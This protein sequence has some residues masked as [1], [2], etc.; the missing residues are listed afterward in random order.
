MG[1]TDI[2]GR[3]RYL[4]ARAP[5][6][7]CR[8][9]CAQVYACA[10]WS[11]RVL[12]RKLKYLSKLL[13]SDEDTISTRIFNSV[14]MEDVYN[15][16]IIQQCR[17]LEAHLGTNVLAMC[18]NDPSNAVQ[19]LLRQKEK[20]LQKDF[21][22]LLLSAK[23]SAQLAASIASKVSWRRLWDIALEKGVKGTKIVQSL[24]REVCR[25][26]SCFKCSVCDSH[27]PSTTTCF[28]HAC[29]EHPEQ[30]QNYR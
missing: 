19:T 1:E 23:G 14:A 20:I 2:W 24:F 7:I 11:T 9:G 3:D 28:E 12:I 25:P 16:S 29:D 15:C 6:I 22:N 13:S 5:S 4:G 26:A 30:V 18:L 21:S 17:M 27:V 10:L 8:I